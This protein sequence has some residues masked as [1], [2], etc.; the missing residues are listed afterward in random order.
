MFSCRIGSY[1]E[2]EQHHG[3]RNWKRWLGNHNIPS[4]DEL[5]YVSERINPDDL[6]HCLGHIH[7]RLKRNK[8]LEPK[9]GWMLAAV[10]GHEI[11]SSY[12]RCSENC[13]ER[14]I[15]VGGE[16]KTQYYNRQV[17]FQ[18][19]T[20]NFNFLFDMEMQRPGEDEVA[21]A[22]RLIERVIKDNPRCFDILVTD[23]IYLRPSMIDLLNGHDKYFISV[24]KANQPELLLEA[25]TLMEREVPIELQEEKPLKKIAIRDMEG[26]TTDSIK[27]AIR[28]VWSHEETFTRERIGKKWRDKEVVSDWMWATTMPQSLIGPEIIAEFG[29]DR[30]KIENEGFNELV[31]YWHADHYF[32]HHPNSIQVMWLMLFMAHAAFH[33]F[34]LRNLKESVKRHHTV[35][36]FAGK[37]AASERTQQW[38]PPPT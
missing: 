21:T 31:T 13:L 18:I 16:I 29:H 4:A 38:W 22:S 17:T 3:D 33:C 26:F 11:G 2:L 5:A 19:I 6:R 24:L 20:E 15:E 7:Q 27:K 9:H 12:H 1:N 32:H 23:A 14:N 10:D 8:I 35:I 30:W 37:I 25:R 28:V 34:H 36:Y